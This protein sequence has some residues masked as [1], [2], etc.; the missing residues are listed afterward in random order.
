MRCVALVLVAACTTGQ[1]RTAHRVGAVMTGA[2]LIG[3][4]GTV[5]TA[6]LLPDD[7][8]TI[9]RVGIAF[10]PLAVVGALLYAAT[11]STVNAPEAPDVRADRTADLAM[12]LAKQAKHAARR[13]DCAEV[14][15][16]EP[17]VRELD[18][19]I[20]RRFRRDDVIKT[21]LPPDPE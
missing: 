10:V 1:V 18:A 11:D 7:H 15:A 20:Y 3:I 21:C 6:E 17:R 14:L 8:S 9:L 12:D 4:I 2:G 13:G 19:G 5:G 16:L